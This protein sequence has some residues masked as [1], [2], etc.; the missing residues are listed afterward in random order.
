MGNG[1]ALG[2]AGGLI[3]GRAMERREATQA[4]RAL[5]GEAA[6][7]VVRGSE[8]AA[9]GA[10][11]RAAVGAAERAVIG[12]AG[13]AAAVAVGVVEADVVADWLLLLLLF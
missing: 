6:G 1:A 11:E 10:V 3:A 4:G 12:R 13:G 5:A 8:R 9:V 2:A 7:A